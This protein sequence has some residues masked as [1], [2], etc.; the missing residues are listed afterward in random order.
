MKYVLYKT[1]IVNQKTVIRMA[2]SFKYEFYE[3]FTKC[4]QDPNIKRF[5]KRFKFNKYK[6]TM[7]WKKN[8]KDWWS[9]W[10]RIRP[11][12]S[13]L[14]KNDP[15]WQQRKVTVLISHDHDM[16]DAT[17]NDYLSHYGYHKKQSKYGYHQTEVLQHKKLHKDPHPEV[18]INVRKICGCTKKQK[19]THKYSRQCESHHADNGITQYYGA[20]PTKKPNTLTQMCRSKPNI[21]TINNNKKNT[22]NIQ[23]NS[24]NDS[25]SDSDYLKNRK[26]SY[27]NIHSVRK[28]DNTL[29]QMYSNKPSPLA[30]NSN[31]KYNNKNSITKKKPKKYYLKIKG[32]KKQKITL[33]QFFDLE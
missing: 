2:Q 12:Q 7:I 8:D 9:V 30:L 4:I 11:L 32:V 1:L 17:F 18:T 6:W 27:L 25:D 16:S 15:L 21:L 26:K 13:D 31:K 33:T 14:N 22:K 28:Q 3:N 10:I 29:T 23:K 19:K 5:E 24:K 20:Y